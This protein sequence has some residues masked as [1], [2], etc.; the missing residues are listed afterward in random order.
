MLG[1]IVH[2][3]DYQCRQM[4][5]VNAGILMNWVNSIQLNERN[6]IYISLLVSQTPVIEGYFCTVYVLY[7]VAL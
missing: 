4:Y 2:V 6:V 3:Y 5:V 1:P 7:Y